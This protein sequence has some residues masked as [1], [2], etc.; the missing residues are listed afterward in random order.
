MI[1]DMVNVGYLEEVGDTYRKKKQWSKE[2]LAGEDNS[3]K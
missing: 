3:K 2:D 1:Q